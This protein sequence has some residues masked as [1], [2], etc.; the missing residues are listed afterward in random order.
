MSIDLCLDREH[1]PIDPSITYFCIW[2]TMKTERV[3]VS[4]YISTD[5]SQRNW[6]LQKK[7]EV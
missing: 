7:N 3:R 1:T 6:F 4:N 2:K 5:C